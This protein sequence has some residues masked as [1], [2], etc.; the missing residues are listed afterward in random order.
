MS[1]CLLQKVTAH[2][3]GDS[4]ALE[5]TWKSWAEHFAVGTKILLQTTWRTIYIFLFMC[6]LPVAQRLC[7]LLFPIK[8]AA[9][10]S[11]GSCHSPHPVPILMQEL[12]QLF[13]GQ[14]H[15]VPRQILTLFPE[16]APHENVWETSPCQLSKQNSVRAGEGEVC[17]WKQ[18]FLSQEF[19]WSCQHHISSLKTTSPQ[20]CNI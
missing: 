4:V 15:M 12:K 13:K 1:G 10:L 19:E 18:V 14:A 3:P 7:L 5:T 20:N 16:G 9:A 2:M 6:L 17:K 11:L 8:V